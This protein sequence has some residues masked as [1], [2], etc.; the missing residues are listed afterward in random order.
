M[1]DSLCS[2]V[3]PRKIAPS[4][5]NAEFY[6]PEYTRLDGV[7]ESSGLPL[8]SLKRLSRLFTGPFGSK[9]PASLYNTEGGIPLLRVQNIGE[10]FIRETDMARIPLDVHQD[11]IRSKL[12]S[13]DIALA[14]AGRLGALSRIPNHIKECNIT[15]HI[16]GIKVNKNKVNQ[17]YLSAFLLSKY[18]KYQLQR[19]AVGTI[20][21]YLGIEETRDAKITLPHEAI[22]KFIGKYISHA[23]ALN[24]ISIDS[25][26]QADK[27]FNI[28]F[29]THEFFPSKELH[30]IVDLSNLQERISG[31]FYLKKYFDLENHLERLPFQ[32]RTM[33]EL[34]TEIIRTSTP[35]QNGSGSIPC[36]LTSDIDYFSVDW[37]NPKL[38]IN[39]ES[40]ERSAG[41]LSNYDIV[42]SS[43]C[44]PSGKASVV[45][46]EWLP[47]VV[48][49][50]VTIVRVKENVNPAFISLYL[51]STFGIMQG[52][53]Y[54]RGSV[55]R[56]VYPE[57]ISQFL[58]SL[59]SK[60]EQ[61]KI[62]NLVLKHQRYNDKSKEMILGA[63]GL[64]E[65][66]IE[67]KLDT[68]AILSGKLKAPTW[69]D[70]E[71]ELEGI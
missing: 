47:M 14:K 23:Q 16:V 59:P 27:C 39:K 33:G 60:D 42:Y 11:I 67:G 1:S 68:D 9:L 13:G 46:P 66:L 25:L 70:I 22:Q 63:C 19:Q 45:L 17:D 12:E 51:N 38:T 31:D 43:I 24:A 37:L 57:D 15:Q 35:Q 58:I 54:S 3:D 64:I 50:D 71:K 53:R 2:W 28:I 26:S 44:S 65:D 36:I 40:Y 30:N 62:G 10:L 48:G 41:I 69:E 32:L 61:E 20:I 21:K 56:R 8:K 6:K 18:G 5:I 29:R 4:R 49:G 7:L 55:Q 34:S 52:E